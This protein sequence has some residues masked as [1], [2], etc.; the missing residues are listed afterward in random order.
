MARQLTQR[1][2]VKGEL[3]T[4]SPLHFGGISLDPTIDLALALDGRGRYYIPGTSLAGALRQWMYGNLDRDLT[5]LLWGYQEQNRGHASFILVEDAYFDLPNIEI[6]DGVGID[7]YSGTAA[8]GKKFDQAIIPKGVKCNFA[9]SVEIAAQGDFSNALDDLLD[10]LCAGEIR[11]GA[12]KTRGLGRVKLEDCQKLTQTLNTRVG[13]LQ[14]LR[15]TIDSSYQP[16]TPK[17]PRQTAQLQ[18][19]IT[20]KPIGAVMV[21][22]AI[23]GNAVDAIPLT[24]AD[25]ENLA[26]VIPGSS[27]KGALRSQAER[28][29]RTV[30]NISAKKDDEFLE[31]VKVPIVEN[32]FG[33]AADKDRQKLGQGALFVDD[34]YSH[35]RMTNAAWQEV[36]QATR[37]DKNPN[38]QQSYNPEGELITALSNAGLP[39]VQQAVHVAIDRWT[40]GAAEHML[41]SNLEPFGINWHQIELTVNLERLQEMKLP[42]IAL[43]LL[44]LRDLSRQKIPL[45]YGVNRGMGAIEVESIYVSGQGLEDKLTDFN[46]LINSNGSFAGIDPAL[47]NTIDGAWQAAIKSKQ[48][49]KTNE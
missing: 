47:L 26:L 13:M 14:A 20:W 6:R 17:P 31:Q 42:A 36:I 48:E 12:A 22:D 41:Y 21:K 46:L 9:M 19:A 43:L 7:R 1:I 24:S 44:L 30:M 2:K 25:G 29:V 49:V 33:A 11:L 5:R 8:G 35:D 4:Q 34:C 16:Y 28:I 15:D 45:G 38:T 3:I 23:E 10:A 18:I 27:I 39:S 40:G 37:K 32:L